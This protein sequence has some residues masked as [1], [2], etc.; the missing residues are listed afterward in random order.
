M[1]LIK[2]F[3]D[4]NDLLTSN[5]FLFKTLT[6]TI[7]LL[8][9]IFKFLQIKKVSITFIIFGMLGIGLYTLTYFGNLI[10]LE[11]VFMEITFNFVDIVLWL[12]FV[13][14]LVIIICFGIGTII[15][16]KDR[17]AYRDILYTQKETPYIIFNKKGKIHRVSQ[18]Y[19]NLFTN[20]KPIIKLDDESVSSEVYNNKIYSTE[21]FVSR[22]QIIEN[23]EIVKDLEIAKR[24]VIVNGKLKWYVLSSVVGLLSEDYKIELNEDLHLAYSVNLDMLDI[25]C[26]FFDDITKT[27]QLN[28]LFKNIIGEEKSRLT[29]SEFNEY[30]DFNDKYRYTFLEG[31]NKITGFKF[32]L[33]SP[34]GFVSA[35]IK[36]LL[37]EDREYKNIVLDIN[38]IDSKMKNYNLIINPI[39]DSVSCKVKF[40]LIGL[41]IMSLSNPNVGHDTK[42]IYKKYLKELIKRSYFT[43]NDI[44]KIIDGEYV[45]FIDNI[46]KYTHLLNETLLGNSDMID[47]ELLYNFE[48]CVVNTKL[49]FY[50]YRHEDLNTVLTNFNE[51]FNTIKDPNYE[52][53]YIIYKQID[54]TTKDRALNK[55]IDLNEN[56]LENV[57]KNER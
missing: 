18:E 1:D 26:A 41:K 52:E 45:I 39:L 25:P 21:E 56:F 28:K 23:D 48:K 49:A 22:L 34:T 9:V 32:R 24:K 50:E 55:N 33:K 57:L 17:R 36:T 5:T 42:Y 19:Y 29:I 30:I 4:L 7:L 40:G 8:V 51:T 38:V 53:K 2:E 6:L 47:Y 43:E 11:Y 31:A 12:F 15:L 14:T 44:Y 46:Y 10:K 35:H 3:K 16:S 27:Y 54:A 37:Y 20:K 13:M